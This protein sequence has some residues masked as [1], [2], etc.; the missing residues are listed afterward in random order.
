[1][2]MLTACQQEIER[3]TGELQVSGVY[4]RWIYCIPYMKS[5]FAKWL[6]STFHNN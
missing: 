1:M 4:S 3:L 2:I 6:T 5:L